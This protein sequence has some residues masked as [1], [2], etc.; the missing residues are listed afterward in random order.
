M[1][2]I[3]KCRAEVAVVGGWCGGKQGGM[4]DASN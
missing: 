4:R 3:S 1:C 2:Q